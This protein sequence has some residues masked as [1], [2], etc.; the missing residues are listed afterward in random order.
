VS[1]KASIDPPLVPV[2]PRHF[3]LKHA[4][5][6]WVNIAKQCDNRSQ[7]FR[8]TTEHNFEP[9]PTAFCLHDRLS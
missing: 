6:D 7:K 5:M 2:Y 1:P 4:F 3:I 8:A 9:V